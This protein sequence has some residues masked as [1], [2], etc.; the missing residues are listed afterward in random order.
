MLLRKILIISFF[1]LLI[2]S[3]PL[4]FLFIPIL[5]LWNE[6]AQ[7]NDVS[8]LNVISATFVE[9]VSN[10]NKTPARTMYSSC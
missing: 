5:C 8:S 2:V 9:T 1:L 3:C 4:L 7:Y 10:N 6:R